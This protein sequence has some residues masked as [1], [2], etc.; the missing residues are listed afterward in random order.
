MGRSLVELLELNQITTEGST[1]IVSIQ[2]PGM[3]T[4]SQQDGT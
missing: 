2:I 3:L 1:W 4:Y